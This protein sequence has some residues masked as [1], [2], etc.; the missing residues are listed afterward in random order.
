MV[1]KVFSKTDIS[2]SFSMPILSSW[3]FLKLLCYNGRLPFFTL[4][5]WS[6]F[7]GWHLD[8]PEM[9]IAGSC[10][11]N[12]T[13]GRPERQPSQSMQSHWVSQSL[14]AMY[15]GISPAIRLNRV[16]I[17]L[18]LINCSWIIVQEHYFLCRTKVFWIVFTFLISL[19]LDC[20]FG[21]LTVGLSGSWAYLDLSY[22]IVRILC[23]NHSP[24]MTKYMCDKWCLSSF[25]ILN[26][27]STY[28]PVLD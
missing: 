7:A 9:D 5:F 28:I 17:F 11:E 4:P 25:F 6:K 8:I 26:F 24:L 3:L 22:L 16:F 20:K 14:K 10:L 15:C 21:V 19:S 27:T 2:S 13:V 18:L 12:T 1:T 23:E